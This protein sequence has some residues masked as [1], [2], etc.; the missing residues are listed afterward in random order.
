VEMALA[1]AR[2]LDGAADIALDEFSFEQPLYL[3]PEHPVRMQLRAQADEGRL[4]LS[5]LSAGESGWT[6]HAG[7]RIAALP[8]DSLAEAS[9]P[10]SGAFDVA[11]LY[12]RLEQLGAAFGTPLR[13]IRR[14]WLHNGEAWGQ[15]D[16]P[17]PPHLELAPAALDACFQLAVA[18]MG[19]DALWMPT[20]VQRVWRLHGGGNPRA[21]QVRRAAAGQDGV[22][23]VDVTLY[24]DAGPLL[25]LSGIELRSLAGGLPQDPGQWLFELDW[26]EAPRA[27][28]ER[29]DPRAWLLLADRG[30]VAAALAARLKESGATVVSVAASTPPDALAL[31]PQLRALSEGRRP[32]EVVDLRGLDLTLPAQDA[33]SSLFGLVRVVQELN[34]FDAAARR[35]TLVTRGARVA[36][37]DDAA[38]LAVAQAPLWGLA[39]AVAEEHPALWGGC[40][41]LDPAAEPSQ[42]AAWLFDE[43]AVAGLRCAAQRGALRLAPR[44]RRLDAAAAHQPAPLRPDATYLITGGLGGVGLQVAR[45]LVA[46]GARHLAILGRTPLAPRTQWATLPAD[47]RDAAAA[48]AV[49]GLEALGASV[50]YASVDVGDAAALQGFLADHA[51]QAW[52]PI[53]GVVH[54][55]GVIDDCLVA[56]LNLAS[57]SRVLHGKMLGAWNLDQQ[58][59]QLDLFVLFSSVAAP[60]AQPGQASY[61][62]ANAFLDALAQQRHGRGQPALSVNWGVWQ[63]LGFAGT[64]GG[65]QALARLSTLGIGAFPVSSGLA[66]LGM[67]LERDVAQAGVWPLDTS[68]LRRAL[69]AGAVTPMAAA[70]LAPLAAR[71]EAPAA[72]A[73]V[74]TFVEQLLAEEAPRQRQRLEERLAQHASA[75]LRLAAGRLERRTPM[76]SYGLNSLMAL[77]LRNRIEGDLNLPLSATLLWNYPT[78]AALAEHLLSRL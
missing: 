17:A 54:A 6:R 23:C 20:R 48:Q 34:Q 74:Q 5:W 18:A 7:A 55:A 78:V 75:V 14:A 15:I 35:C 43:L 65:A 49:R 11:A 30:G 47:S 68:S 69:D 8:L 73:G 63:G 10:D 44:L 4:A 9:P 62:A 24:G 42:H 26:A 25:A 1:A 33:A 27:A 41:D 66:A 21:L 77:E 60:L 56:E 28:A 50:R 58:L 67:L 19:G 57:L 31:T 2:E 32:V 46:R 16:A 45:W 64:A 71:S 38:R 12:A 61:A 70:L 3:D 76:G 29:L 53:R 51:A 52:P 37:A 22:R 59:P 36:T 72:A 40:L 13:A 39:A